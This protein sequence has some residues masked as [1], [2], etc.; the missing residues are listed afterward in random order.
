MAQA[1]SVSKDDEVAYVGSTVIKQKDFTTLTELSEVEG[2]VRKAGIKDIKLNHI[3]TMKVLFKVEL[4]STPSP[5]VLNSCF[6][7]L[8]RIAL[9]QV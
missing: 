8:Q 3:E 5:Q 7:V 4:I 9:S 6:C 1:L 2:S